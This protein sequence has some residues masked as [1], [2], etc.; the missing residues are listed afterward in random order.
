MISLVLVLAGCAQNTL[1]EF[2]SPQTDRDVISDASSLEVDADTTRFIGEVEGADL[3]LARGTNDTLCLI[4]IRDGEWE[5]MGCGAGLGVG[6]TL[7]SGT[8]IEAG[9]FTFPDSEVG[10]GERTALSE[11]VTVISYP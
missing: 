6:S 2:E 9:T 10:E 7:E 3:Y 11:S 4:Q 5:Q 8:R 1:P